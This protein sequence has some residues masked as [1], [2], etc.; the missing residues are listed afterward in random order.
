MSSTPVSVCHQDIPNRLDDIGF[1][2][3]EEERKE[4][5]VGHGVSLTSETTTPASRFC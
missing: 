5:G 2:L 4:G 1:Q 3:A